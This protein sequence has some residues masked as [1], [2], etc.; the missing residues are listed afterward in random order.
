ME[1]KEEG[2][3]EEADSRQ[4]KDKEVG[5]REDKGGGR[6]QVRRNETFY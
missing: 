5:G 4:G 2:R 3:R 6:G 1:D